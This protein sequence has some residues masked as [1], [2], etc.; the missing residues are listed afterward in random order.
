MNMLVVPPPLPDEPKQVLFTGKR[1]DFR[2]LAMRGAAL[3]LITAGFYRF[4]LA[5]DM[6]RHVWSHTEVDGDS[7]EYT[8][9]ARELL[10]GFLIAMAI[11]VPVYLLYFVGGIEAERVRAFA[12]FPIFLFLYMFGQFAIYRARRYRLTRTIWRGVRFWMDGSG[13][14]YALRATLWGTLVALTLGFAWPWR[15]AALERYKMRHTYY[16]DLQ[17]SFVGTGWEFFK[18]GWGLWLA[19]PFMLLMIPIP[20][21][22]GAFKAIEWKWWVEGLRF[23]EVSFRSTLR[24]DALIGRYWAAVGWCTLAYIGVGI[25]AGAATMLYVQLT[26]VQLH[27]LIAAGRLLQAVP[28]MIILGVGYVGMVLVINVAIRVTLFRD[29]W[30]RVVSSVVAEHLGAAANVAAKGE[31]VSALGEGIADG[32][33]VAG[34]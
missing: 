32:L 30:Q 3:E 4:W 25:Y 29:V 22:Y 33:D 16:G 15:E 17:G 19:S 24:T 5:T 14:S 31:L 26:G 1:D 7:F 9:R 23:G 28:M 20:F 27:Q 34:F 6:R 8:G 21:I 2:K 11:L 12:S 13:W 18:R 10:I